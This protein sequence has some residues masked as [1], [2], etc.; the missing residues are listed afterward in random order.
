MLQFL[1]ESDGIPGS[2]KVGFCF[3]SGIIKTQLDQFQVKP[4]HSTDVLLNI[5]SNLERN[6][7]CIMHSWSTGISF[8]SKF[9][10]LIVT[11]ICSI[12]F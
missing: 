9:M 8:V 5:K 3:V 7:A 4:S 12:Y 10:E 2:E 11:E 1:T 6:S